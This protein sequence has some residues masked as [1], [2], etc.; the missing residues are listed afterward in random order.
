M[1][2]GISTTKRPNGTPT[3]TTQGRLCCDDDPV[4]A[5]EGDGSLSLFSVEG[6][7]A[8]AA[9]ILVFLLFSYCKHIVS[10]LMYVPIFPFD[11][12]GVPPSTG[13]IIFFND[14]HSF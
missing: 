10:A 1:L 5:A 13:S 9:L 3:R 12:V 6:K 7:R 4:E 2:E 14:F 11:A 8:V